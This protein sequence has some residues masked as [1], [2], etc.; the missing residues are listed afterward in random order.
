MRKYLTWLVAV[1]VVIAVEL[2]VIGK[3]T[4]TGGNMSAG[5]MHFLLYYG[6]VFALIF[7]TAT[8]VMGLLA[9]DR[10]IVTPGG[11]IVAQGVHRAVS[12][13]AVAFLAIHIATEVIAGRAHT[14]DS[15]VP[16]LDPRRT[17]YVGLG[18]VAADVL[19]LVTVTG[20]VRGWFASRYSRWLWRALHAA[21][22]VAWGLGILHGL[23]AGRVAKPYVDWGY[24]ACVGVVAVALVARAVLSR[25]VRETVPYPAATMHWNPGG[26]AAMAQPALMHGAAG[27]APSMALPTYPE[28]TSDRYAGHDEPPG[29]PWDDAAPAHTPRHAYEPDAPDR[30]ARP[31]RETA[32]RPPY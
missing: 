6:G 16:F 11:R 8:V 5:P 25:R 17:F 4:L 21:A 15:V 1:A 27:H 29:V 3:L 2:T 18:T 12:F 23:H 19:V 7:L 9:T 22:Y 14:Y 31:P 26:G 10:L 20:I 32:V 30:W 13:G 28:S 24:L